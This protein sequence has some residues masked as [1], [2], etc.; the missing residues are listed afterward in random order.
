M[1]LAGVDV[2]AGALAEAKVAG[3]DVA[4]A[5][6]LEPEMWKDHSDLVFTCGVLIHIPPE[7]LHETMQ[8]I[9]V[10]SRRFVLAVEYEADEEEEIEY[11]GHAGRL[12][13]RPFGRM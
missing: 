8:Q 7:T 4:E 12:W 9:A 2:N 10:A 6:S 13:K 1:R 11:R 5:S 3:F